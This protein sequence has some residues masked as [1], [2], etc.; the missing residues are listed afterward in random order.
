M[1]KLVILY[2][3]HCNLQTCPLGQEQLPLHLL[4]TLS[5]F[6]CSGFFNPN[7]GIEEIRKQRLSEINASLTSA[8]RLAAE[9]G[10]TV[11]TLYGDQS[12]K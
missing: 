3:T 12:L 1:A 9:G 10:C 7:F 2:F 4:S 11:F 8:S 6:S 5:V